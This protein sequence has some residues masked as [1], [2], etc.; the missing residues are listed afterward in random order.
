MKNE[1][2][3]EAA[4]AAAG[5]LHGDT[6]VSPETTLEQLRALRDE[7][8]TLIDMVERDIQRSEREAGDAL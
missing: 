7:V 8:G 1:K 4:V 3:Y 2:L 5:K 6:S